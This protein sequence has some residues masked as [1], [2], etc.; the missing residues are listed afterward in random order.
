[1]PLLRRGR[2]DEVHRVNI[3][4]GVLEEDGLMWRPAQ[5]SCPEAGGNVGVEVG[6]DPALEDGPDHLHFRDGTN[7]GDSVVMVG[8]V[9]SFVEGT[10]DFGPVRR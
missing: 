1:M 9:S 3:G 7:Y 6:T 5:D 10:D 8:P 4:D 2:D